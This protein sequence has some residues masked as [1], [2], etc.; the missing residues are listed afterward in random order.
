MAKKAAREPE[1]I[2][3]VEDPEQQLVVQEG[4]T[5]TSFVRGIVAFMSTAHELE[6]RATETLEV[7]RTLVVPKNALEDAAVQRFI[8][9][10]NGE[11]KEIS[12]HWEVAGVIHRWQRR[13]VAMRE[14]AAGKAEEA[15][16]IAN[17]LH[18]TW[19]E[20]ERRRV[21]EENA[22]REREAREEA[23][24]KRQL[25]LEEAEQRAVALEAASGELSER[26]QRFVDLYVSRPIDAVRHAN[27]VGY[28]NYREQAE[29]LLASPKIKAAIEAKQ[30]AARIRQQAAAKAETPIEFAMEEV[31]QERPRTAKVTTTKTYKSA[32]LTNER[33]LIEAILGGQHGI[34]TT[35][36]R[37]DPAELN[38][39]ARDY[40]PLIKR[41]PGVK[42]VEDTKSY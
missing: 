11:K 4:G 17:R 28:K 13:L 36:L 24:R 37:I 12:G 26:E 15:S 18:N 29:R 38:K 3:V 19:T 6:A 33:L 40:G 5:L 41:W 10:A 2:D 1:V 25:E 16:A 34:P 35:L 20:N 30:A 14:R 7:A 39:C 31:E 9:K 32:Q 42:Y 8:Q 23:E 27:T 22:R 21:D